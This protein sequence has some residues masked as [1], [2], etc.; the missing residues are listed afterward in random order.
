MVYTLRGRTVNVSDIPKRSSTRRVSKRSA[1]PKRKT[2]SPRSP[3]RTKKLA[4]PPRTRV[5]RSR[6]KAMSMSKHV[7]ESVYTPKAVNDASIFYANALNSSPLTPVIQA[8]LNQMPK[9]RGGKMVAAPYIFIDREAIHYEVKE[10]GYVMEPMEYGVPPPKGKG[11]SLEAD[12]DNMSVLLD[13]IAPS[14]HSILYDAKLGTR[15]KRFAGML[16]IQIGVNVG[17]HYV[18]YVYDNGKFAFFDSGDPKQ[19]DE[20]RTTN[21]TYIVLMEALR[22]TV[23]KAIIPVCNTGVFETAA[24]VS[25]DGYN[26]IGQN[27]FCH[28]W[29]LWFLY[30]FNVLKK[31]MAEIDDMAGSGIHADRDNLLRIKRFVYETIIP[32]AGLTHLYSAPKFQPFIYYIND[33]EYKSGEFVTFR[34][35]ATKNRYVIPIPNLVSRNV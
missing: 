21:N 2:P 5:T 31:T 22:L 27:I 28:S 18:A 24:G 26:Y 1:T 25:E 3:P 7:S 12:E 34:Q 20:Q 17:Q 11:Y 35:R 29:S 30:Q 10:K 8:I 32:I 15:Y 33:P 9:S 19:C 13:I 4:S 23:T 6:A 14:V 16:G